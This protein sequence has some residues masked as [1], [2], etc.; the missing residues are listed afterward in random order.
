MHPP[1]YRTRMA[2]E[3]HIRASLETQPQRR[4]SGFGFF[5]AR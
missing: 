4:R 3:S 5:F 1:R 2:P